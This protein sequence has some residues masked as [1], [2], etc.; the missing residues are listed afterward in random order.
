M[1]IGLFVFLNPFPRATAPKEVAFYGA[2]AVALYLVASGRREIPW[3]TPL[4]IPLL[5]LILWSAAGIVF[6]LDKPHSLHDVLFHLVKY[7]VV[8]LLLVAVYPTRRHLQTLSR[9][10]ILSTATF[11]TA[12]MIHFYLVLDHGFA[13]RLGYSLE[14]SGRHSFFE[15]SANYMGFMT[16][17][18]AML[19]INQYLRE[20]R[21]T[22]KA[23]LA[24]CF[25]LTVAATLLTQSRGALIGLV[26]AI[27]FFGMRNRRELLLSVLLPLLAAAFIFGGSESHERISIK[28]LLSN[29]RIGIALM[30]GEIIK[31]HPVVGI[32][33]GM[34]RL[35]NKEFMTTYYERVPETY[36]DPAF[37]VSPHNFY[38]DVTV[39]LG[40]IGLLLYG[41]IIVT[42]SRMAWR[43]IGHAAD[44]GARN[45]AICL[46]ASF[47]AFL[48]Q[49]FFADAAFGAQAIVFY[50]HLAMIAILWKE[51][52][53]NLPAG[54]RAAAAE[55]RG[56]MLP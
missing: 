49:A 3:R 12:S 27:L 16:V 11:V 55:Y 2:L 51:T 9:I 26:S 38:V 40:F 10:V 29:E 39:R 17:F 23:V 44:P 33:F 52:C 28:S 30:Y 47:G 53:E 1:L 34:E 56:S 37:N 25:I 7:V 24:L 13:D 19:S 20:Y 32:G 22:M 6:A 41:S 18:A 35:Q 46:V 48:V 5:L 54:E 8:A 36:Q 43:C 45:D 4:S 42:A 15:I 50:M 31:E 14:H 21:R